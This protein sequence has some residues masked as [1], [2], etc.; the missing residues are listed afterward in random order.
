MAETAVLGGG[1]Y[2]CINNRDGVNQPIQ[3]TKSTCIFRGYCTTRQAG[4]TCS[5]CSKVKTTVVPVSLGWGGL[6]PK[7]AGQGRRATV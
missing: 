2:T 5:L 1:S 6:R 3:L 7:E 4:N